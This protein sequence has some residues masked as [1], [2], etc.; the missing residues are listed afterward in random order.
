MVDKPTRALPKS[1]WKGPRAP[2]RSRTDS[3]DHIVSH[4]VAEFGRQLDFWRE[5]L[6][7]LEPLE[8]PTDRPRPAVR[9]D[10]VGSVACIVDVATAAGLR[11]A[12]RNA[13]VPL[14]AALVSVFQVLLAEYSGQ[15][16]LTVGTTGDVAETLVLRGDVA[17]DPT[18]SELFQ[19]VHQRILAARSHQDVPFGRLV[20]EL[21]PER[22]LSR[23]PLFQASF[24]LQETAVGDEASP[25]AAAGPVE[26]APGARP[27]DLAMT[28][29]DTGAELLVGLDYSSDLFDGVTAER[30]AGHFRT[31]L[32]GAAANPQVQLSRLDILSEA[33]RRQILEEWN[34]TAADY[35]RDRCVHQL[36]EQQ[37][38]ASPDALAVVLDEVSLS[39]RELNE[40]ANRLAHHLRGLGVGPETLVGICLERSPYMIV[41]ML[42]ILKA[43]GAYVPM[44]PA[45]PAERLSFMK[46]DTAAPVV[47]T[48]AGL[49]HRFTVDAACTLVRMDADLDAISAGPSTDPA[50]AAGPDNLAY[51]VY[52]SGSTGTPKGVQIQHDNLICRMWEMKQRYGLTPSDR[53]LQFASISFD[54][55]V[56]QIFPALMAGA[57]LV[58]RG[59]DFDPDAV[60]AVIERSGVTLMQAPASVWAQLLSSSRARR[61]A[62]STLCK[63]VLAG[64]AVPPGLLER[65]FEH[66][67]TP[68]FNAYGP[69]ET[70]VTATTAVIE[71]PT[72]RV[73]IGRPIANTQVFVMNRSGRPVPV[74]VAGEL[75]IGGGSVARG[76]L[77]RP[78]LTA[79]RFVPH[80][81]SNDPNERV[82]RTG[83]VVRWSAD[84]TLEFVG[85]VDDQVKVRGFR[86]E[87]GEIEA[88]LGAHD[89]IGSCIVVAREDTPGDK[90]LVA[91]VVPTGTQA[92][93][94]A[95]LQ[96]FLKD[97]LPDHMVPSAFVALEALPLTPNGKVDRKSLP[98]PDGQRLAMG[99]EYAA[100]RN[101]LEQAAADIWTQVLG[102]DKVGIH[103][104]FF[105][106]GGDSIVA[107]QLLGR[108]RRRFGVHLPV[109]ELLA[110]PTV[111]LFCEF[112]AE[113]L[114]DQ[115]A[116]QAP[117]AAEGSGQ[118]DRVTGE[119]PLLPI[120]E[121]FFRSDFARPNHWNQTFLIATPRLDVDRLRESARELSE[122]HSAFRLRYRLNAEGGVVQYYADDFQPTELVTAT[123]ADLDDAQEQFTAWQADFD[124][125]VG[126]VYRVGYLDGLA[127]G[128]ARVFVACHHLIV[129]AVS[130]RVLAEDL[131]A[132]YHRRSLPPTGS[133]YRQW[134]TAVQQYAPGHL[135]EHSYWAPV[136]SGYEQTGA[137]ALERLVESED[138]MTVSR[139]TLDRESTQR[140][141]HCHQVYGT[142]IN[143]VL[144]AAFS[145]ALTDLTGESVNHVI[146]EGHG[147]EEIAPGL[148]V[149][150]TVGW[151]T[152][153][154]PVRLHT[155]VDQFSTLR[156]TKEALRGIPAK[157]IGYGTL[158]GYHD[159]RLPR[160]NFNYLGRLD[161]ENAAASDGRWRLTREPFGHPEH[162]ANHDA[163]IM[164]INGWIT[165]G[166]FGLTVAHKLGQVNGDR[167]VQRYQECLVKLADELSAAL[168]TY[169]TPSDVDY[170]VSAGYLDELQ[171]E[172]EIQGVFL[173]NSL[174][175]GFVYQNV[176]HG[177]DDD[178][179]IVQMTW[180]YGSAIDGEAMREAWVRAQRVFPALR[181]RYGWKEEVVQ[182]IDAE[183]SV[184]WRYVDLSAMSEDEAADAL[185]RVRRADR[186]EPYHLAFGPLFRVYLVKQGP[187][188]FSCIFSHHHSIL[189]GWSN[190]LLLSRV[191]ELYGALVTGAP[192][193]T[194]QD[195]SF[196]AGQRYLQEHR[197]DHAEFWREHLAPYD[198]RMNLE[199]LLR[200]DLRGGDLRIGAARRVQDMR[201]LSFT[202]SGEQLAS[203]H[204]F[205]QD[206]AVTL[207][208][209]MQYA[210]HKT[211]A[212]YT[213]A[214]Q[215][216]T[217]SV[218]SGRGI[219]VNGIETSVG[220]F[221]NTLPL[222]VPHGAGDE[223][224]LEGV[225]AVQ[226]RI[227][228]LNAHSTVNLTELHDGA[229]RLFDTLF[230]HENW[231][232]IST[233]G[234]QSRLAGRMGADYEKLDYPLSVIVAEEPGNVQFR[235]V[236][237]AELFDAQYMA[238]MLEMQRH[239]LD[240]VLA[241]RDRP[242]REVD[243]LSEERRREL[244]A[245][246]NPAAEQLP[247]ART[248]V[249]AFEEQV[250]SHPERDAVTFQGVTLSYAA[251]DEQANRL[252]DLLTSAHGVQP[253]E[254]VVL[255]L[256]KGLRLIVGILG[257]LKAQ[258][259]YVLTDPAYPDDR[260]SYILKDTAARL[261]VSTGQERDRLGRF[262]DA[263]R[264]VTV[265]ALDTPEAREALAAASPKAV[266]AHPSVDA[267]MYVLYTSGTTGAPKGVMIEHRAYAQTV[268][269]VKARYF[270][271]LETVST[272]S[273][274]NHV[275]DIFGLEYGLP[276][277][278][279]G[280]LELSAELPARL[281]CT[282]LDFVQM[283][284]SV[285]D[286]VLDRLVDVPDDLLLLVGGERLPQQLLERVLASS[287]DL[288]NVYG[289][290][291]TTIWS[292]S[293]LYRHTDGLHG[294]PVSI[295][296]PFA[297]ES[298][299]VLDSALRPLPR[300][301][302]GELCIGGS[303]QARG[304][305]NKDEL[306]AEG[307]ISVP[308]GPLGRTQPTR[309]YRTGDLVRLLPS[310][311]LEFIGRNDA[312][313]KISG[314]R[315]ELGEVDG[316]LA[317]HPAVRQSVVLVVELGAPTLIGYYVADEKIP[318]AEL[319]GHL[320][321]SLPEYMV[322]ARCIHLASMPLT[323]N[324]KI[325]RAGLPRPSA[326]GGRAHV[327][328]RS[329]TEADLCALAA[330]LLGLDPVDVGID[331]DFFQL[332][333]TSLLS[334]KLVSAAERELGIA[335]SVGYLL[336]HRTVRAFVDNLD[337]S[338]SDRVTIPVASFA[339]PED[340]KLSF[341][342]ERL[343][344]IERF[345][346][347]TSAYNLPL[348]LEVADYADTA[349]LLAAVRG[350][351]A[352]H[353]VLRTVL[354]QSP[355]GTA[356]QKVL[357]ADAPL[358]ID[359]L[360]M[361]DR[362][363]MHAD[364]RREL[365]RPFDLA[366]EGPLRVRLY[367][368]RGV[369]RRL[370]FSVHH[371]AFDGWSIDILLADLITA[372]DLAA[373]AEPS[374]DPFAGLPA[375]QLRYRDFAVWQREHL[376]G[377]RLERLRDFW[378]RELDDYQNL[379]LVPDRR[380]PDSL[381]YRGADVR[382]EVGAEISGQLRQL[383]EEL[384]VSL[385]SLLLSAHFLT[386][387]CFSNQDD[388]VV[389]T[390]VANRDHAQLADLIGFFVNTLPLR[391]RVIGQAPIADYV[392]ET[393]R[394][395]L[396]M[397][398][399]QELPFE[400]LLGILDI[401]RDV[402]QHPIFQVTFGVQS[403]GALARGADGPTQ[404]VLRTAPENKQL[405]TAARFDLSMF[406]DDSL[407]SLQVDINYATSLLDHETVDSFGRTYL[408]ILRQFAAL[409]GNE[410][411]QRRTA[412]SDLAYLDE[413]RHR[414]MV[415]QWSAPQRRF[416]SERLLHQSVEEHAR[417]SP[418]RVALVR[419]ERRLTYGELNSEANRL[420]HH[421]LG[422][423]K[424]EPNSVVLLCLDRGDD[425][426]VSILG[427]L[428][429]G[430]G[431]LPVDPTYPDDRIGFM[432]ADV[433]ACTVVTH[434]RYVERLTGILTRAAAEGLIPRP[435]DVDVIAVDDPRAREVLGTMPDT[436][437]VTEV[438]PGDLAY[439]LYTSGTTGK[440]KGV[441]QTHA[442]VA[443]L[444]TALEGV[445]DIREDDVWT[446]FHNY[447]FDF[448]VWE[449]W[450]AF[451]Y[452][453]RLV[454]PTFE[455]TR[456]PELYYALCRAEHVTML[457]QTPTAFY[458]FVNVALGRDD[459][460]RVDDLRYVFFG[461]E[462]LNVS[463]LT[464][465]FERYSH[466]HP[467]LAMGYGTT[468]TT[469]F[470]CYKLYDETDEGSTDIGSL[471]PDVAGY[472]L[473][474]QQRL[475]PMG[476]VGELYIGGAG[477]A[478]EL[479]NQ[480]EMTARK[481]V[482]NPFATGPDPE[483]NNRLYKSGDL[484]RWAPNRTLRFVGRNDL[485]VKIRGHRI[486]LGEIETV[487]SEVPGVLQS[488]V[489]V[490]RT[491]D[492]G[493]QS[494]LVGYYV[495][496]AGLASEALFEQLQSKLPT[497][498]IPAALVHVDELPRKI[499][500]KL[501]VNALP[502]PKLS[503]TGELVAPRNRREALARGVLAEVLGVDP[504]AIG[505]HDD[506]F[507]LGGN[508]ILSIKLASRLSAELGTDVSIASVFRHRSVAGLGDALETSP[509]EAVTIPPL[510]VRAET[511]L[512]ASFAQERF[513]FID[514]YQ[515]GNL[516]YNIHLCYEVLPGV[517]VDVLERC[518][519]EVSRR[520]EVLRTVIRQ[521]PD[522]RV[523]QV[524]LDPETAPLDVWHITV[525]DEADLAA[526]FGA[527]GKHK[528]DLAEET[529]LRVAFYRQ[530]AAEDSPSRTFVGIHIH[531][532]AFDGW[533]ADV[534]LDEI[535]RLYPGVTDVP[536]L[537]IQY[538]DFAVWERERVVGQR[539]EELLGYWKGRLHG[540]RPVE[541]PTDRIRPTKIDYSGGS[542]SFE[543][544]PETSASA[545]RLAH[546]SGVGLFS[547]LLS[548]FYLTLQ[549]YT[550]RSDLLV[551]IPVVN[552]T[553]AQ[554]HELIGCFTNSL[555]LDF[556]IDGDDDVKKMIKKVGARVLEA[557]EH[558]E[559][560]FERLVAE[561]DLPV[562]LAR[563]PLF[564]IWFDV[565]SFADTDTGR[566]SAAL[567]R[568][569][570]V[571]THTPDGAPAIFANLD[572]GLVL[573][574]V[575]E[576]LV[577]TITY[578][579]ALFD[580]GTV[581]RFASTYRSILMQFAR[582]I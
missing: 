320:R 175:Q 269:A 380:R 3:K 334:I 437:P 504:E 361:P 237:A 497:Y 507:Q 391:S 22:D 104:D 416:A 341:A 149:G 424:V 234:W 55:S 275:F 121:W 60:V 113:R 79:E 313:I 51:I 46:E 50:P 260:I 498:M 208:A 219:P 322:P 49:E 95:Q 143:D 30:M 383:A 244:D 250:R 115:R 196:A 430:G 536:E 277:W 439:V 579:T 242:W 463:L 251:L 488:A 152:T 298:V 456:D 347:G 42:S 252:A 65:W 96:S 35:P 399:H 524:V 412:I 263:D 273:L 317:A 102:M 502:A 578:A 349:T 521:G 371:V 481:F 159:D 353:D 92:L 395:V 40:Q 569:H 354:R 21:A 247:P 224:V 344:F 525:T 8:L 197:D 146:L 205:T 445:Y 301:A 67:S 563:H 330:R 74:G 363:A 554:T 337:E 289:P 404:P 261:V 123:A 392:R 338:A 215:T 323:I 20:E 15:D 386:L 312:Q 458:Q 52:T 88:V 253:Q 362:E 190:T 186:S 249:A 559:L 517:D 119:A 425:I 358:R 281:D 474:A 150:R 82:Y 84:G 328:P 487:L 287:V 133:S 414:E 499:S 43:G 357:G 393:A 206:S 493:E 162:P 442:N 489:V 57:T 418:D 285:C 17:G 147:R 486:E 506:F 292:T 409:A 529:P 295:G 29:K 105:R 368:V 256:D 32:A 185:L 122:R 132:L 230:I 470:T 455:Q 514:Q 552:R 136:Q 266:G 572:F 99:D 326:V 291:E 503:L 459:R 189:D 283:T 306:T 325:D 421:L 5:Q 145:H 272:H 233:D 274:T 183:S 411:R 423:G 373:R 187:A 12:A 199:G 179:Y 539:L 415:E 350:V 91:Y 158:Y 370:F 476:A 294:L 555:A 171:S 140:L 270:A 452:G 483:W 351:I 451:L 548:A 19:R 453:G 72:S 390:P 558:Q 182:V 222:I 108:L 245:V 372:Y 7:G 401:E 25:E 228:E 26:V 236:Y 407:D 64:E 374:T 512:V 339:K 355:D 381:D 567:L 221:I 53:V 443:R 68:V 248:L 448:T 434:S 427:T 544:D 116:E 97:R 106:L 535:T 180:E 462:A 201:E 518:I 331:D 1:W 144:L 71:G 235:L 494:H 4:Q 112:L 308:L 218:L 375:P 530:E 166:R 505:V 86:I 59:K 582:T 523:N 562:D 533:S 428:K 397:L 549:A 268:D 319:D 101:E 184:D 203:L 259:A 376:T 63:L 181:L 406:V 545:R 232:K 526:H 570:T 345:E 153:M 405:Y 408:T 45:Y 479:L 538:K 267:L 316:A 417:R 169:L 454:V 34:D 200:P 400:Q 332:G 13:G 475:L 531:H 449:M 110:R 264:A 420:A 477:L 210:W 75:W 9:T 44:D 510:E 396:D 464:E 398:R 290:T 154:F 359:V 178:A 473:D 516:G 238:D 410:S 255:C 23:T 216:I 542:V 394:R 352:R 54:S 296:T 114:G 340:Q 546:E 573:N 553:N 435:E 47:V 309:L 541:L 519:S 151:F 156:A 377:P 450:G 16:D 485:Q 333:G 14:S 342:Q 422:G 81:F 513:W 501:D 297:G 385:F 157:G 346:S 311:E 11:E 100:P 87:L 131:E 403:F 469:V 550:G 168:R 254:P 537:S 212:C 129:D 211:L 356:Y 284:P 94:T 433:G 137:A 491:S 310:G 388:L 134:S 460:D 511:D 367:E 576:S 194:T 70:T 117:L 286:V 304:Y 27:C 167:L 128:S 160:I 69:S 276:L 438:A 571:E 384:R 343:W 202:V 24:V 556:D 107:I 62:Q 177:R 258:A 314:H 229:D 335:T 125:E 348:V 220:L 76:Y 126:P 130:W 402:S 299:H 120:Q 111:A 528:F 170:V 226:R 446:L 378:E 484:V 28:V 382:L 478:A 465:W 37:A 327:L 288:V 329:R 165:E 77:N 564:Q 262:G 10:A 431:Y 441:P 141:L 580:H 413:D 2:F 246:L 78:E 522:G 561:L 6:A 213:G 436:D 56:E 41:A 36:V 103:D 38:A 138:V 302:V 142:Q 444:F 419:E 379:D 581:V 192:T 480:P 471:I 472:V 265:L 155:G 565:N 90:R 257:V 540:R 174:Q 560:P 188:R 118:V 164:R 109:E 429:A 217:G 58:L 575:G 278:T 240:Q 127:D 305:L 33:E 85:R 532:I 336:A 551:G 98:A 161:A 360:P 241:K 492:S 389:G 566:A 172:R 574:D 543:L 426:V 315:I 557:Q 303:G 198:E 135:E 73:P 318:A 209:L 461:G 280:S 467:R 223:S 387:R 66:S 440:P 321:L 500:G 307:F 508:S 482:V 207:N 468:E 61:L 89:S 214:Q 83:D 195:L 227:N 173:A 271:D 515:S 204:R 300:G 48:Q 231:P 432:L 80:P 496:E 18:V 279:G 534:L 366:D 282:G 369:G 520:H 93:T 568:P 191:H 193:D 176:T 239:V 490:R 293:R 163:I 324:G 148:D 225:Q 527:E 466:D 577:G 495:A 365:E 364:I 447:V 139:L 547:V 243:L 457:C 509:R 124:L 39:Y 31:L